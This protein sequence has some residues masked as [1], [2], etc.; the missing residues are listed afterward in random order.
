MDCNK[1]REEGTKALRHEATTKGDRTLTCFSSNISRTGSWAVV[2]LAAMLHCSEIAKAHTFSFVDALLILKSDESF[3]LDVTLN[4]DALAL[5]LPA[6]T[7]PEAT[8]AEL[9]EMSTEERHKLVE[10]LHRMLLKRVNLRIDDAPANLDLTLP[11][12][13]TALATES[14]HP[15]ILGVTARFSGRYE[16]TAESIRVMISR[17]L[18]PVHLTIFEQH[19]GRSVWYVL[20]PG[21]EPPPFRPGVFPEATSREGPS[22]WRYLPLGFE[23]ILPMGLDHIL[24]VVGLFLLSP[25]MKPLLW[26]TGAF[27]VAH[28]VTLA[29]S[30]LDIV[31]LSP[32]IVEPLIAASIAYVAVENIVTDKLHAWRSIVVFIFGLL[33]G[34]GFAGALREVGLPDGS[35]VAP[36]LL[37]NLGVEFGQISVVLIAFAV[38]GWFRRATWYRKAIVIPASVAIALVGAYWCIERTMG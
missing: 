20:G 14:E 7:D 17:A 31:Q 5:G 29:L 19:T 21:E 13:D 27:T 12:Q 18:G 3:L 32:S 23:H 36:L 16:A 9:S 22:A 10:A 28:S 37:F 30:M 2:V 34:M 11:E 38:V 6:D 35:I 4:L 26:Q 15:T 33:H 1:A 25:R 24:F 8:R